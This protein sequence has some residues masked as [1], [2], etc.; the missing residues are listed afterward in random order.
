[1][2]MK[3]A[4][5]SAQR[6]FTLIELMIVVAIIGILAAVALPQ[7]QTYAAKSQVTRAMGEAGALKTNVDQCILEGKLT[8]GAA[9]PATPNNCDPQ[10]T[11]STILTGD[12]Q[13]TGAPATTGVNGYPQVLA[14][15]TGADDTI[16]AKFGSSAAAVLQN[17]PFT[18]TWTR[19]KNGAWSCT[20]TAPQRFAPVGCPGT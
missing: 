8:V 5:R 12:V 3:S 15:L 9:G 10:A 6:G 18:L 2:K 16:I 1:M 17:T 13:G 19:D 4:I 20:T 14:T 11:P 7:Y